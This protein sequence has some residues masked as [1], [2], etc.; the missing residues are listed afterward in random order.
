M[1]AVPN[2][3]KVRVLLEHGANVNARSETDRA[4]Y[5][6]GT[7]SSEIPVTDESDLL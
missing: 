6:D 3:E 1:W 7:S 5:R 4:A 2:V